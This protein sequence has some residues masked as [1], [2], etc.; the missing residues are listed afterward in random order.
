MSGT[1]NPGDV[2]YLAAEIV[3]SGSIHEIGSRGVVLD[4]RHDELAVELGTE[5]VWCHA[6]DVVTK[7]PKASR[8]PSWPRHATPRPALG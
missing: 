3:A 2:V 1:P 6:A 7:R 4:R 8:A 5:T